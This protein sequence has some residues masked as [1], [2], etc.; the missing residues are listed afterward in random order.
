MMN[1][2]MVEKRWWC[3]DDALVQIMDGRCAIVR[4]RHILWVAGGG[5]AHHLARPAHLSNGNWRLEI[6][7]AMK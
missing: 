4:Q 6:G 1:I 2:V 5:A 3:R 7:D